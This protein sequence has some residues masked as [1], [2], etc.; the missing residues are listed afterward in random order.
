M[1]EDS[2]QTVAAEADLSLRLSH[3][4]YCRFYHALAHLIYKRVVSFMQWS[5]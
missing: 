3:K 1:S 5:C 2:D 4:S